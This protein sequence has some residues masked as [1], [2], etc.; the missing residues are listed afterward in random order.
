MDPDR[1]C[2]N[3][4]ENGDIPASYVTLPEGKELGMYVST[5][6][7]EGAVEIQA[8]ILECTYQLSPVF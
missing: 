7:C 3:L 8:E 6:K 1:R 2:R 5:S 4:I